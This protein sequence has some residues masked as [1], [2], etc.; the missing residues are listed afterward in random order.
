[1]ID[2][3]SSSHVSDRKEFL[4]HESSL[5]KMLGHPKLQDGEIRRI[6]QNEL[7]VLYYNSAAAGIRDLN[8]GVATEGV[9]R[10][11][12]EG[13][14]FSRIW[15]TLFVRAVRKLVRRTHRQN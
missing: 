10:I 12:G 8:L 6:I 1:M 15:W 3:P 4:S 2:R 7:L 13:H 11:H 9:K 5:R 14:G